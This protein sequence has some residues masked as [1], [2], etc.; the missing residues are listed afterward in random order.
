M[1]RRAALAVVAQVNHSEMARYSPPIVSTP[2][3]QI[4]D[5]ARPS[6]SLARFALGPVSLV[7][8]FALYYG[9]HVSQL[10]AMCIVGAGLVAFQWAS[11]LANASRD[12]YDRAAVALLAKGRAEGLRAR[13]HAAIPFRLFG[14]L[15]ERA[16]RRGAALSATDRTLEAANA[17]ADAVGGYPGGA[18]PRAVAIGFAGAAF[19]AGWN[20]DASRAYRALF[21][22]DP[23]LP[24]VRTRLAHALTRLGED[25]EEADALL[26]AAER[27]P[28]ADVEL[29]I[30]RAAWLA[31]MKKPKSARA[32][33]EGIEGVPAY[34]RG[35]V[36]KLRTRPK[37]TR[38]R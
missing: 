36:E 23:E 5:R 27:S 2:L 7:V 6:P 30:A 24:R 19:E 4:D 38:T 21:E 9:A 20:R 1:E 25:L 3:F 35:E 18:V 10:A 26:I 33:L 11:V 32:K 28:R 16:A 8:S 12:S 15:A 17:W 37:K 31:A 29:T 13:L 34:L 22:S 14:A